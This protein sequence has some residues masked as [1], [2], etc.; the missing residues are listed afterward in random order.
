LI[1]LDDGSHEFEVLPVFLMT[2]LLVSTFLH[3]FDDLV[4]ILLRFSDETQTCKSYYSMGPEQRGHEVLMLT[5]L[6]E[7][8]GKT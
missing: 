7:G 3:R 2:Y 1:F 6:R 8:F 5:G 4:E